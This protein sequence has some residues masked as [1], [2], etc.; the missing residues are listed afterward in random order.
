MPKFAANLSTMF[1]ELEPPARFRAA[2][3]AGFKAVEF[4]RPYD[5]PQKEVRGWLDDNGLKF[6]LLNTLGRGTA[7]G[8]P[9]ASIIPGREAQFR[10][11]F[12]L[13]LDYVTALGGSMIHVTAGAVPDG[14]TV[15]ACERTFVGNLKAVSALAADAGITLMLEPLNTQSVPGYLHTDT[16]HTRRIIEAVGAPNVKLQYD[17]F[18]M[19]I[20]QG[21]HVETLAASLDIIG[22][23]Q[24]SS[25]PGRHEP[26]YGELNFSYLFEYLDQMGYDGWVAGEYGPK[27]DSWDGLSWAVPYGFNAER[28]T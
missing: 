20:M 11:I 1:P 27:G 4:L 15:E 28:G 16:A 14:L 6:L 9:G 25:V 12:D 19:Q 22:H 5:W 13:A 21:N 2:A 23:I 18:H 3:R 7:T 26:Q 8:D 17:F 24:F 10:E